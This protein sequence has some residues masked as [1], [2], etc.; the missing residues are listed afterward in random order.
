MKWT[1]KKFI[2]KE[3]A[4]SD[5]SLSMGSLYLA[6]K[7]FKSALIYQ[8]N[9]RYESYLTGTRGTF[10]P[11][12]NDGVIRLALKVPILCANGIYV[13]NDYILKNKFWKTIFVPFRLEL[14]ENTNFKEISF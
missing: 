14:Y 11:A 6:L 13:I 2:L 12:E 7:P 10:F 4:N 3:G 1:G 9:D 8:P 5:S